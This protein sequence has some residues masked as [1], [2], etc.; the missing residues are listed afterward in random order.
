MIGASVLLLVFVLN[1]KL[2]RIEGVV[3]LTL[4]ACISPGR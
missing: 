4:L 3:L 2:G 1:E